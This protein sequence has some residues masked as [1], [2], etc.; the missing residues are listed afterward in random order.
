M[1]KKNITYFPLT[2]QNVNHK[3]SIS[4]LLTFNRCTF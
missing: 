2:M 4:V 3:W 1:L